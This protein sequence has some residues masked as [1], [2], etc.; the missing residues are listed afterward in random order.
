MSALSQA[1]Q[2]AAALSGSQ[3]AV[4]VRNASAVPSQAGGLDEYDSVVLNNVAATSLA[5][6]PDGRRAVTGGDTGEARLWNVANGICTTRTTRPR[7]MIYCKPSRL[8]R[9]RRRPP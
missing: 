7:G 2:L 6:S 9:P 1:D 3:M 5:L 8:G 4:D